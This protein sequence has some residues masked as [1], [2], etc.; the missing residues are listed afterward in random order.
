M[1]KDPAMTLLSRRALLLVTGLA[2]SSAALAQPPVAEPPDPL[3]K[4]L[5]TLLAKLYAP[6]VPGAAVIAVRDGRTVLRMAYG[7]ADLEL[8]VPLQPDMVFRIGSMTKQFTAVAILMLLEEGKLAV[9][10]PITKFLPDY[11]TAGKT[12][13]VEHLLTHTSGIKSYTDMQLGL[14]PPRRHRRECSASRSDDSLG[15]SR[16]L[17]NHPCWITRS[18]SSAKRSISSVVV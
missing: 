4:T 9:S 11:P 3:A 16:G 7:I 8:R 15:R 10:D 17:A 13:T 2:L 1:R 18:I 5:D 12:I 6:D 14:L